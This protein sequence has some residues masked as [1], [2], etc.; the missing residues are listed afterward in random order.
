MMVMRWTLSM[1]MAC[2]ITLSLFYFM[3]ALIATGGDLEQN[4]SIVKIVDVEFSIE[5]RD[6]T[7]AAQSAA[8]ANPLIPDGKN[9]K[10]Q[11]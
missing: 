7:I 4:L 8:N 5:A 11:G 10:S 1:A 2:G 6:D 9:C 3:Q